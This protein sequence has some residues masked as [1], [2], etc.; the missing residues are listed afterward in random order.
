MQTK[1]YINLLAQA[2]KLRRHNKQGSY[3]TKERYYEAY[4]RFIRYIG[5]KF[6]LEKIANVSGKHLSDYVEY[7]QER[8]LA[9]ATVQTD[10]AAIRFWHDKISNPKY[11]LPGNDELN[12]ERRSYGGTDRT[13]SDGE[14]KRMILE[15]R[16]E[17]RVDYEACIIIARHMGLRIH[18]VMRIDTAAARAALKKGYIHI[19]GKGGLERDVPI[20]EHV[21]AEFEKWLK[22]TL[23]GHKL[24]V[25][26]D[27]KT[28]DAISQLQKFIAD[29]RKTAQDPDSTRPMTFHGLRHGY[30]D[31]KYN[32]LI[33][34]G[35][36]DY[37]AKKQ[38]S[39]LLGHGRISVTKIYLARTIN[40]KNNKNGEN[41]S[42]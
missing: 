8:G 35:K 41:G 25:P 22:V 32:Q 26:T 31:D 27:T 12:L 24:F 3:K 34:E 38:V 16:R 11:T 14:V 36:S 1:H 2:E 28:H 30:A 7:M 6:K 33:A 21:R 5:D 17:N 10:L 19:K 20:N 15:C 39:K 4:Q 40:R 29:H 23:P 37:A 13:W 42:L 18:E 9:A